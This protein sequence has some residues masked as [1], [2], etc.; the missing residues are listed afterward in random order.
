[1][2]NTIID[3]IDQRLKPVKGDRE[4]AGEI[5]NAI[6]DCASDQDALMRWRNYHLI[7]DVIR[8]EVTATGNCMIERISSAM[9]TEPTVLAPLKQGEDPTAQVRQELA[10]ANSWRSAGMVALAASVALF[11]VVTFTPGSL[12]SSG[13]GNNSAIVAGV[14]V[15]P[16]PDTTTGDA[17]GL[18]DSQ[19][20]A[21]FGQM[22]VEHG[23]FTATPGLNGL[24]AYAKLV[25][26]EGLGR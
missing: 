16:A 14:T 17:Q 12:S 5:N 19:F 26:N 22:L 20:A 6:S 11:A 18:A 1:M 3:I 4:S 24:V 13:S 25:S 9:E 7:G 15:N 10:S 8:G 2:T 23:E 21:E